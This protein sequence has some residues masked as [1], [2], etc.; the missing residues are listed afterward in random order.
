MSSFIVSEKTIN[1]IVTE[2]KKKAME[3]SYIRFLLLNEFQLDLEAEKDL[4]VMGKL[5]YAC[6]IAGYCERYADAEPSNYHEGEL[7]TYKRTV[8]SHYTALKA[9]SC[10]IYQCSEGK[11]VETDM[12][13]FLEDIQGMWAMDIVRD[14]PDYNDA[15]GWGLD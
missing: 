9:L 6:N 11:N 10:L 3:R 4:T 14:L 8:G 13:K 15:K 1:R 7:Y 5:L 12:Y 2:L